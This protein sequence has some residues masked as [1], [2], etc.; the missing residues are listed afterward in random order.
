MSERQSSH[1]VEVP[2]G[3]GGDIVRVQVNEID[4]SLVRVGRGGRTVGR[5]EETL[6]QM[7]SVIRPVANVFV[8][9]CRRMA[10]PPDEATLQFGMS[11]SADAKIL[12][13]GSS[14]AANF[15]VG[16]TWHRHDGPVSPESGPQGN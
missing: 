3:D 4:E 1:I 6:G 16:M 8:E 12:I 11:L 10:Y 13:A 9:Q 15:S 2:L 14:V 5:A 7:L